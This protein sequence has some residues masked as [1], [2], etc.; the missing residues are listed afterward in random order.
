MGEQCGI[1]KWG[2]FHHRNFFQESCRWQA[3]ICLK[4]D[5]SVYKKLIT[6]GAAVLTLGALVAGCGANQNN[7][8]GGSANTSSGAHAD[9][10][11][12]LVTDTGGLNDHGFNYLADQGL[13]KA[14]KD[15]GI[16]GK[17]VQSTKE[18]DYVPNLQN[19]A[20]KGYQLVI[21]V[22]Y[23]MDGAVKQVAKEYPNTKFLII[24]DAITGMP[25]VTS[26][27][28][29]TEQCG[30]LVG[31]MAGLMEKQTGIKGIN[32]K[33]VVGVVGG[34]QIPP[35]TSYIA[36]FQQGVQKTDP[37]ATVLVKFANSFSDQALGSQI[38]QNEISNGAD[39]IFP[40]AGGTGIGSIDAAQSAGVY[41]IGVDADQNYLAPKTV[42]TSALKGVDTSTYDVI[43]ET[44]NKQF[45]EG[46]QYFD[47]KNNGVGIA[48]PNSAV[49][50]SVIQQ[51]DDL[52]KQIIDGTITV[53]D[54][55]Q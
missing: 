8:A 32:D 12:G 3:Q 28:Y 55:M 18:S 54:K 19:F 36:G 26:A 16:T 33:N 7:T 21:A 35:V 31:A 4:G 5:F 50:Q 38:A 2:S 22:G 25:N 45:K 13:V 53:S 29:K 9:F 15:F 11:V 34:Q 46:I 30:Y 1:V 39:I 24:D 44:M 40:V 6:S 41:A 42:I 43:Q 10:K 20:Q 17:V 27:I 52:K 47:L 48:K 14:E 51:V 49:P 23:L 37:G